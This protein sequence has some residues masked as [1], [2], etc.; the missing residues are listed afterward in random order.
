MQTRNALATTPVRAFM[1][2]PVVTSD[3]NVPCDE[4]DATMQQHGIRHLPVLE[5][6]RLVGIV[7][8]HDL[9]RSAL[10]FALGY[11]ERGRT[12]LLHSLLLKEVMRE[13]PLT[14]GPDQPAGE[15]AR[16]LLE[17]RIG[18]LPVVEQGQL[19]GIVT[20]SDLMRLLAAEHCGLAAAVS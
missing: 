1:T 17:H 3:R 18:C 16:L 13:D 4:A 19:V 14:I 8:R 2:Q 9:M 12:K 15:A 10:A 11:G 5:D 20:S 6:G 7:G